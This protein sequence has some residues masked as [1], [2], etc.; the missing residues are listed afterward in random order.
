MPNIKF[1]SLDK[2]PKTWAVEILKLIR[3]NNRLRYSEIAT[4][5][6]EEAGFDI[7]QNAEQLRKMYIS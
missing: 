7:K 6:V 5:V 2:N 3:N 4:S 1:V